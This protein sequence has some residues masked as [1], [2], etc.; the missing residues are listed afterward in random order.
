MYILHLVVN[1]AYTCI[2]NP[3][4]IFKIHQ[5][6]TAQ[7]TQHTLEQNCTQSTRN[8]CRLGLSTGETGILSHAYL[9][10]TRG[11]RWPLCY[12]LLVNVTKKTCNI[13]EDGGVVQAVRSNDGE[14][15]RKDG[16]Y[17]CPGRLAIM[18][19]YARGLRPRLSLS[20]RRLCEKVKV[21]RENT[22]KREVTQ[23]MLSCRL[24][25]VAVFTSNRPFYPATSAEPPASLLILHPTT[26]IQ[27]LW[28]QTVGDRKIKARLRIQVR[29]RQI[30]C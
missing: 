24:L 7:H 15:D 27:I 1:N 30:K 2:R 13:D 17:F 22:R 3:P 26:E 28:S 11:H 4:W 25:F 23:N 12:A 8:G 9:F 6:S 10:S 18:P 20:A 19:G 29:R 5:Q 16:G 21:N 14:H